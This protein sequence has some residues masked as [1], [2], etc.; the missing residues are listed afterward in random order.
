MM[1]SIS[2]TLAGC[3]GAGSSPVPATHTTPSNTST[4]ARVASAAAVPCSRAAIHHGA[5][6]AWTAAAWSDSSPGFTLPYALATGNAA[7]PFFFRPD[8]ARRPSHE[9]RKHGALGR[10]LPS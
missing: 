4:T 9:S 7:A 5:P 2:L 8:P 3:G 10:P 6:P 1:V